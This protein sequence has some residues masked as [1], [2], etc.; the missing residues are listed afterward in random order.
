MHNKYI[1]IGKFKKR[2]KF[3]LEIEFEDLF[4]IS[5]FIIKDHFA[6]FHIPS[7]PQES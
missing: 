3:T 2:K 7:R 6:Q 1:N 4:L 5:I